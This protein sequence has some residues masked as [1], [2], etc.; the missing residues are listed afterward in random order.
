[1][2]VAD[3]LKKMGIDIFNKIF[4]AQSLLIISTPTFLS[5]P[6][7]VTLPI[8]LDFLIMLSKANSRPYT[9]VILAMFVADK[10]KKMGIG[11]FNKIFNARSLLII[12]TP[13][14][15]SVPFVVT[16]PILLDF[17]I[18]LSKAHT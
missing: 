9:H 2:F 15:L 16:L 17:L 1:M 12:P 13:T 5:V 10:L 3:K 7:V 4:N 8:L 18:M 6:F 11:I 14:F